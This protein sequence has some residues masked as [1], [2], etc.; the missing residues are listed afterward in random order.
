MADQQWSEQQRKW[1]GGVARAGHL[2]KGFIYGAVG[3]L[4]LQ[5]ALGSGQRVEGKQGALK[6]ILAQ[7]FGQILL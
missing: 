7:P 6:A 1:V 4:A 2:S 5:T 3:L